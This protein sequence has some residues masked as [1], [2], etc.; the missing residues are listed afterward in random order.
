MT[1][2]QLV[3]EGKLVDVQAQLLNMDQDK[4]DYFKL[5][6]NELIFKYLRLPSP[7]SFGAQRPAIAFGRV[8]YASID[9][10]NFTAFCAAHS[11]QENMDFLS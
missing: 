4:D 1:I 9:V 2:Q 7:R 3:Q 8:G 11:T 5:R 6:F 10:C